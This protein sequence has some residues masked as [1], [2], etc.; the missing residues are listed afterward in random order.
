[1]RSNFKSYL[2]KFRARKSG[3]GAVDVSSVTWPHF[4][5]K[6][7]IESTASTST[8]E[9]VLYFFPLRF[10]CDFVSISFSFSFISIH[11]IVSLQENT[12]TDRSI[13]NDWAQSLDIIPPPKPIPTIVGYRRKLPATKTPTPLPSPTPSSQ[14]G[15]MRELAAEV[16][17]NLRARTPADR[18]SSFGEVIAGHL[19][20]LEP[21]EAIALETRLFQTLYDFLG[22]RTSFRHFHFNQH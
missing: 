2:G 10:D 20:N 19:R 15:S 9:F 22:S 18:F 13:F 3:L 6:M 5:E 7:F 8:L 14:S 21:N 17:S 1:M 16:L 4:K 11:S 12:T